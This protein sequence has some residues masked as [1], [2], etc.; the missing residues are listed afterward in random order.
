[1]KLT[2]LVAMMF[3]ASSAAT[4]ASAMV[5]SDSE[6]LSAAANAYAVNNLHALYADINVHDRTVSVPH[7]TGYGQSLHP[8]IDLLKAL[9]YLPPQFTGG[10]EAQLAFE[11]VECNRHK[12][13]SCVLVVTTTVAG[14][15][16]T[17]RHAIR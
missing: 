7:G 10:G 16:Q 13:A 8:S 14:V 5:S 2:T 11:P 15:S 6:T 9:A 3:L 17:N 12:V 4:T 1:M